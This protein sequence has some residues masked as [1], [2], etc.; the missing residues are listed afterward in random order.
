M[1]AILSIP[2]ELRLAGLFV[3][4]ACVGSL[5]NLG[6]YRLA[7]SP[8]PISP[9]SRGPEGGPPRRRSDLIPIFGWL[10]R[11]RESSFHGR[12]FWIRPMLVEL[13]AAFGFAAM[14]WWETARLGL[15]GTAVPPPG[16]Q[17]IVHAQYACHML[18]LC[19]MLV[20]SLIDMDE[21]IIP[22]TITVPGAWLG[23]AAAAIYPWSLLPTLPAGPPAVDFLRVT[24]PLPWPA[25]LMGWPNLGALILGLG[26]WWLWSVA[27]MHRTW[28]PRHGWRRAIGLS[29]ARLA[30]EPSTG[31]IAIMGAIGSLAIMAVW[32]WPGDRW[33][34]LLSALVGM[35][36]GGLIIWVVRIIGTAM[37][38][39]EAMGFG[40]VTLMAMIGSFLGW[41]PC[42]IIFFLAPFAGL[43]VGI[44]T[45]ILHREHEIPYG[46]FLC[47][48][49]AFVIIVWADIWERVAGVF[50]LGWLVPLVIV[51]CMG[52]MALLLGLMRLGMSFF[53][54]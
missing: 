27:L 28:Y 46:P 14:Y 4:G 17:D 23:L 21:K 15:L 20:A 1:N 44:I 31:R 42:L 38:Q 25:P 43:V 2:V 41:Q 18:L 50:A 24:S 37:L 7:W 34:G 29:L 8:R 36:A 53:R 5:I 32:L 52:L 45:L 30:R 48:A 47:L 51:I 12:G 3:L 49:A 39:R 19:L 10:G 9:W 35:A 11:R 13:A 6:T 33:Q 26:C 54:R 22:D 40:D 16:P